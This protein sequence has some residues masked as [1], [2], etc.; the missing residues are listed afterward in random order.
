MRKNNK[1]KYI[2]LKLDEK[3]ATIV[4]MALTEFEVS[5][6]DKINQEEEDREVANQLFKKIVSLMKD[7]K[8]I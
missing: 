3:Q 1:K 8:F 7:S 5:I 6:M 4:S 2:N